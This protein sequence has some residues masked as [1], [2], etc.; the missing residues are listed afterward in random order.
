MLIQYFKGYFLC[1]RFCIIIWGKIQDCCKS[2]L[3][4]AREDVLGGPV[5][6][7][8]ACNAE[9]MGSIPGQGTKIPHAKGLSSTTTETV[10]T[11]KT[12]HIPE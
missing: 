2:S 11:P 12:Q 6:Q 7:N 8:P 4:I 5:V 9:D 3:R 10:G 1:F